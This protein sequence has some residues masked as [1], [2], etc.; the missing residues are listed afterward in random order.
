[1]LKDARS[2]SWYPYTCSRSQVLEYM[3]LNTTKNK[4][5]NIKLLAKAGNRTQDL[6]HRSLMRHLLTPGTETTERID[7][8]QVI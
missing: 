7:L 6:S 1:M 2:V 4:K 5:E 8:R 3:K